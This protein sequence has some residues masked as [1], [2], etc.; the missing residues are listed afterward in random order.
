MSNI[1]SE[2]VI[3]DISDK[4]HY[5]VERLL[6][7]LTCCDISEHI[8]RDIFF[9]LERPVLLTRSNIVRITHN[10]SPLAQWYIV[11][12]VHEGELF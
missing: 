5:R 4:V 10:N 9:K 6:M 3:F 7:D 8:K 1:V 2:K 11:V 12:R